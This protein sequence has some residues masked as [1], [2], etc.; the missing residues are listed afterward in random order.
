MSRIPRQ[1]T[2]CETNYMA[3][4]NEVKDRDNPVMIKLANLATCMD[5]GSTQ[6]IFVHMSQYLQN[7]EQKCGE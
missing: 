7:I 2:V 1:P 6:V 5:R 3:E 4:I